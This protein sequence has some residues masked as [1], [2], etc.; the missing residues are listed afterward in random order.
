MERYVSEIINFLTTNRY[1]NLYSNLLT[2][3]KIDRKYPDLEHLLAGLSREYGDSFVGIDIQRFYGCDTEEDEASVFLETINKVLRKSDSIR[4][5]IPTAISIADAL[6]KLSKKLDST[7]LVVFYFFSDV[8]NEKE[9]DLFRALRRFI[10]IFEGSLYL[11]ILIISKRPTYD[12][13]LYPESRLDERHV[14]YIE[15]HD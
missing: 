15:Y 2:K 13:E 4:G 7:T 11:R 9:K 6:E 12:W 5:I 3:E 14:A 10:E 8:H 1:V